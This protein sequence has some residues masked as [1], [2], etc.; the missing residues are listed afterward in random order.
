MTAREDSSAK[1]RRLLSE[2]MDRI[3]ELE[4]REPERVVEVKEVVREV[5]GPERV[6]TPA[7][8]IVEVER[9]VYQDNPDHIETIRKLQAKLCQ[10]IS[11]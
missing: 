8:V 1:L 9:I 3:R 6:I 4:A 10:S 7:P 5:P 2:A 11:V